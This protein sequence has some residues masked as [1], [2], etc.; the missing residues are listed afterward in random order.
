M[1]RS[2]DLTLFDLIEAVSEVATNDGEILATVAHLINSGQVRLCGDAT[3]AR[4]DL[5]AAADAAA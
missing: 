3:G 4:I 1:A 2:Y 5:T